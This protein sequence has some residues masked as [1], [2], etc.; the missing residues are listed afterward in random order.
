M[1]IQESDIYRIAFNRTITANMLLPY[2]INAAKINWLHGYIDNTVLAT[3]EANEGDEYDDFINDYIKPI[4]AVGVVYSN[5]EYITNQL[6]DKG[7]IQLVF[8]GATNVVNSER[9]DDYK[10]ELLDN[11]CFLL[12]SLNIKG[13]EVFGK[14]ILKIAPTKYKLSQPDLINNRAY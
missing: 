5:F 9:I 7:L 3:L 4:W 11:I 6:T 2:Q 8:E 13:K 10:N 12:R 14:D 1:E